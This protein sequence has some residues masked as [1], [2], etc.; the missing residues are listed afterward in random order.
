MAINAQFAALCP[1]IDADYIRDVLA[2]VGTELTDAQID[3]RIN[4]AWAQVR[5]LSGKLGN[6]GGNETLCQIAAMLAA[7]FVT[8]SERQTSRESVASEW[9]VQYMGADDGLGLR[10]SLYGQ[11]AIALDCSGILAQMAD[12]IKRTSFKVYSQYDI[13]DVNLN[14]G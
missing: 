9:T 4:I 14:N 3:I 10:S 8:V 7:H 1:T 6:C 13:E 11:S 5:Q 12:G 2:P